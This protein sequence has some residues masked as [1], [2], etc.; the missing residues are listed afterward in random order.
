MFGEPVEGLLG[1]GDSDS[2]L[3]WARALP[4]G[5]DLLSR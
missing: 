4:T 5:P 3:V 1:L 2:G